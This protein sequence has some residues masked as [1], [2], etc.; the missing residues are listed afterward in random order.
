M[1]RRE[2]ELYRQELATKPEVV[3]VS[4]MELTGSAEVRERM[5]RELGCEVLAISAV[6]GQGLA[7]LVGQVAEKLHEARE[8]ETAAKRRAAVL[9]PAPPDA[10]VNAFADQ[11]E[12]TDQRD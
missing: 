1:V 5:Q 2:L 4:K 3:A 8:S 6:T 11:A 10:A 7:Q 9:P 12:L